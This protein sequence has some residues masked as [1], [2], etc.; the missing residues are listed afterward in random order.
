MSE[1][2]NPFIDASNINPPVTETEQ[3]SVAPPPVVQAAPINVQH[4]QTAEITGPL[5]IFYGPREI[6]KTV[7]LLRLCNYIHRYDIRPDEGFRTD[8]ESYQRT[9]TA[10]ETLR[11]DP[12]FAPGLTGV[13]DFLL[14]NVTYDGNNFCQILEAPGEHFYDRGR[15]NDV[16][17]RYMNRILDAEYRKIFVFFFELN[18]FNSDTDFTN[19][20]NKIARLV[21][22]RI[23]ARRDRIIL[24]CNKSDL[25]P[26]FVGGK[27]VVR[28]YRQ[29]LYS[30]SS[31]RQLRDVL[32]KSG[33]SRITFVPFSAGSFNDDGSGRLAFTFSPEHYPKAMW[34]AIHDSVSGSMW[35]SWLRIW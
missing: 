11:R 35:P 23:N 16:Y 3:V 34:N 19:Y 26:Y 6:G 13:V 2:D 14:L 22:E 27:P 32:G 17:P 5:V 29:K 12:Q 33:F 8:R 20:A 21:N 1:S 24:V 15:P 25:H 4:I 10:F 31:F 30:H 18:M 7:T 28:E 9:I